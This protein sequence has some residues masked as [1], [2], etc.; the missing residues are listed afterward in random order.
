MSI[1]IQHIIE[2]CSFGFVYQRFVMP[3]NYKYVEL[4]Y[5]YISLSKLLDLRSEQ[6]KLLD[7]F[8]FVH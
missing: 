1:W 5:A 2:I 7:L 4:I 3:Y 6:H 8:V